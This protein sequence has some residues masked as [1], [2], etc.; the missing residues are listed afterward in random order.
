[1][2]NILQLNTSATAAKVE[3][4]E[5]TSGRWSVKDAMDRKG[6]IFTS[7][8]TALRFIRDEFGASANITTI[9]ATSIAA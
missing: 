7:H 5:T 6:G 2:T 3:L 4:I 1:M 8:K 9:A